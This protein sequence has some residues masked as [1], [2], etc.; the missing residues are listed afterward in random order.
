MYSK[1][2]AQIHRLTRALQVGMLGVN[3]GSIPILFLPLLLFA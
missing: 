3:E 1:D 2:I